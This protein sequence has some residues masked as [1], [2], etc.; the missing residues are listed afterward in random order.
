MKKSVLIGGAGVIAGLTYALSTRRTQRRTKGKGASIKTPGNG[1]N[2]SDLD[3]AASL[4]DSGTTPE[5]ALHQL[6]ELRDNAFESS[7]EKLALALGRPLEEIEAWF[8]GSLPIDSDALMKT[9]M[10][11]EERIAPKS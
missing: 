1:L 9:R 5:M 8:R 6:Q 3:N 7:D 4:D 11:A 2:E 10:L